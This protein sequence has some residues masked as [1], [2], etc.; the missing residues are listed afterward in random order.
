LDTSS[1]FSIISAGIFIEFLFDGVLK[2]EKLFDADY[3]KKNEKNA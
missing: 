1:A 3:L 2:T